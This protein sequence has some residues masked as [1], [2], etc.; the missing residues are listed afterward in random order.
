MAKK[1]DPG[2]LQEQLKPRGN[3]PCSQF[4]QFLSAPP[5]P[6]VSMCLGKAF[7]AKP[8]REKLVRTLWCPRSGSCL[9]VC[10]LSSASF[11]TAGA[12]ALR[13]KKTQTK[14]QNLGFGSGNCSFFWG[15]KKKK[16]ILFF[17]LADPGAHW[18]GDQGLWGWRSASVS[19][20]TIL[21]LQPC[22]PDSLPEGGGGQP[23]DHRECQGIQK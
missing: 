5:S 13:K 20:R 21:D 14:P 22:L 10:H 2:V 7:H 11:H 19:G 9:R 15:G 23:D 3:H 17:F 16:I 4:D 6:A 1:W 12:A 18:E 8:V